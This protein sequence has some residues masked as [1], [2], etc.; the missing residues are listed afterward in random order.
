[1]EII[2]GKTDST[3]NLISSTNCAELIPDAPYRLDKPE[4]DDGWSTAT[5]S[6]H[7]ILEF[8]SSLMFEAVDPSAAFQCRDIVAVDSSR[9][10]F[11]NI[12]RS[13]A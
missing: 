13:K 9:K 1:M 5:M 7:F 3:S 6:R 12:F 8:S 4:A 2:V 11:R 10:M